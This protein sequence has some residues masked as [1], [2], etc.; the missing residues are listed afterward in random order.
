MI[1]ITIAEASRLQITSRTRLYPL[2][3]HIFTTWIS[4]KPQLIFYIHCYNQ[5]IMRVQCVSHITGI[6]HYRDFASVFPIS[7]EALKLGS[8]NFAVEL[9]RKI[10]K[11]FLYMVWLDTC[12]K[13]TEVID[14]FFYTYL[15]GFA[16]SRLKY[17]SIFRP[18]VI[19]N[20]VYIFFYN[21][22][23]R[24]CWTNIFETYNKW[25]HINY[26]NEKACRF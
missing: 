1:I 17:S 16:Q 6:I 7:W 12:L 5:I 21:L 11:D 22:R 2:L 26:V 24:D 3:D 19:I 9:I 20:L 15:A 10:S 18:G 23:G 13:A 14:L 8:P 25:A 4:R